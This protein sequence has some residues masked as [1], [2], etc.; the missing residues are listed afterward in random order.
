MVFSGPREREV[1][2]YKYNVRLDPLDFVKFDV[3][4]TDESYIADNFR[5]ATIDAI[6]LEETKLEY[7]L[8]WGSECAVRDD[9]ISSSTKYRDMLKAVGVIKLKTIL[10]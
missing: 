1:Y 2:A 5:H 7:G 8:D 4:K 10:Q 6:K 3:T 9:I